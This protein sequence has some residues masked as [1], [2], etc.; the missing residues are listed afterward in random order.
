MTTEI[1][2]KMKTEMKHQKKKKTS[3]FI[4]TKIKNSDST[5]RSK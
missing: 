4:G 1:R 5:E 2:R 3:N